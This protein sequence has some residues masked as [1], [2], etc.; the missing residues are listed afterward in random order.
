MY[1]HPIEFKTNPDGSVWI[2]WNVKMDRYEWMKDTLPDLHGK[3]VIVGV[4]AEGIENP[5]P[6]PENAFIAI[7]ASSI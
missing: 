1:I 7:P 2:N 4:T 6:T 5:I 3:T